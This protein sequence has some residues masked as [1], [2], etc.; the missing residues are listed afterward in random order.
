M[1]ATLPAILLS[2]FIS[3]GDSPVIVVPR[4]SDSQGIAAAIARERSGDTIHLLEGTFELAE[5]IRPK[6]GSKL[7]GAGQEKTRLVYRG[8]QPGSLTLFDTLAR[9]LQP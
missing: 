3:A 6:S 4:G 2:C 1:E 8:N 9:M 5:S 7:L